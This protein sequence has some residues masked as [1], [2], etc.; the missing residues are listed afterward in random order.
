M[1]AFAV[2]AAGS[3]LRAS[4]RAAVS[5][6]S[7]ALRAAPVRRAAAPTRTL[8][9]MGGSDYLRDGDTVP[10]VTFKTRE[11]IPAMEAAGEENPFD[12]VDKTSEDYFKGKRVVVFSLP[13]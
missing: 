5:A 11:R 4:S 8:T 3:F 6:P 9:S 12:W 1:Y 13:G 10:S 7:R 2:A